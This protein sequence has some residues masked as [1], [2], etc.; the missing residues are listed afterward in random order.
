M[1]IWGWNESG[2]LGFPCAEVHGNVLPLS[3]IEAVCCL[4]KLVDFEK[5]VQINSVSCGTRHTAVLTGIL[6]IH[7]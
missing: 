3:E 4:P 6:F 1:Y 7:M 5:E 2:Q